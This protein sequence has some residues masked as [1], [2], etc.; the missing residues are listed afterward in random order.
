MNDYHEKKIVWIAWAIIIGLI[1]PVI[2]FVGPNFIQ[3]LTLKTGNT[4][5]IDTPL[6]ANLVFLGAVVLLVLCCVLMYLGKKVIAPAVALLFVSVALLYVSCNNYFLMTKEEIIEKP[7]VGTS[8]TYTWADV[9]EGE[10]QITDMT[11][12]EGKLVLTFNDG[13]V[14]KFNRNGY[15]IDNYNAIDSLLR[16]NGV[17]YSIKELSANK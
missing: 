4:I 10:M 9:E 2:A 14:M 3:L 6:K 17:I 8:K 1:G 16:E 15:M 5:Y 11:S 13:Y 12:G 7:L